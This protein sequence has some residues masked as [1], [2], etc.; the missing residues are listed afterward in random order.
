MGVI[1]Q[2][3]QD[4]FTTRYPEFAGIDPALIQAYWNEAQLYHANDGS[5]PVC[6]TTQQQ[7]LLN[8]MTAHICALNA[9]L[10]GI[11]SA[12]VVGRISNASEGS[13]SVATDLKIP[14]GSQLGQWLA[15]TKYGLQYWAATSSFRTMR[16]RPSYPRRWFYGWPGGY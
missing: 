14:E 15:Q 13:V 12:T 9:P 5:G 11:P 7:S 2:F 3:N 8:M 1:V 4:A 6:N 10:N 16:Y